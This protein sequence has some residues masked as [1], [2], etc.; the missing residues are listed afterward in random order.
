MEFPVLN[1][2]SRAVKIVKSHDEVAKSQAQ[3]FQKKDIMKVKEILW[4]EA[5]CLAQM[6]TKVAM[7]NN[8]LEMI[9]LLQT[10][11]D[12][13]FALPT[14]LILEPEEV[15]SIQ[16]ESTMIVTRKITVMC[17]KLDILMEQNF[18]KSKLLTAEV[19]AEYISKPSKAVIAKNLPSNLTKPESRKDFLDQ[20]CG[21]VSSKIIELK[22]TRD[23]CKVI[24]ASK[25]DA[26]AI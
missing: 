1:F 5:N 16:G 20:A 13:K 17:N 8:V 21:H 4:T 25:Y 15:P 3:V 22:C 11:D 23:D 14:F 19:P 12:D 18:S 10:C 9:K 6:S 2:L 7:I 26:H 24:T